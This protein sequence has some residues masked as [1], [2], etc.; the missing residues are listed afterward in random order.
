MATRSPTKATAANDLKAR[1]L[2]DA[3]RSALDDKDVARLKFS[4]VTE[5]DATAL[6]LPSAT[7]GYKIPYFDIDGKPTTFFRA[8]FLEDTRKGFAAYTDK[9]PIK[10]GQP[11][12]SVTEVYLPPLVN[13]RTILGKEVPIVI[14]E[15]EKKAACAT[16]HGIPTVGLGGVWSFMSK[17]H[18]KHLLDIFH[19]MNL[20]GRMVIICF[21]SDAATN[22]DIVNAENVL[23][24]RLTAEGAQVLIARIQ[25]EGDAK[26]GMDDYILAHGAGAFKAQ[27][28]D[29]AFEYG[30]CKAL[31]TMNE[32]MVYVR[33]PGLL[34]DYANKMKLS[35]A[36][37]VQHAYS[38]A[39][40]TVVTQ[41]KEGNKITRVN[42]AKAWMEWEHR[43]ELRG[44]VYEPGSPEITDAGYLN[45]WTGWGF[46]EPKKGDIKPW[47][48]LLGHLFG[49]AA[50][51][52]HWFECWLAWPI[53]H[54]GYKMASAALLWGAAQGSGKTLIGHTMMKLYGKN[55]AE[56]KDHDLESPRNEWAENK[57][58]I[59]ADDITGSSNRRL[60]NRLKTMITQKELRL[61]P[62]FIPSYSVRDC[63]NYYFTSNDPDALFLDDGDRRFFIHEVMA[64]KL[65]VDQR[66]AFV[67]WMESEDGIAALAHY[68]L[69]MDTGDFDPRAEAFETG[70]KREMKVIAKSELGVWVSRLKEDAKGLLNGHSEKFGD[71]F[72]AEELHA[73]F[74]PNG[75]KRATPNAMARELKR[76]GFFYPAGD[77]PLKTAE[78]MR[79]A[80]AIINTESWRTAKYVEAVKHFEDHRTMDA[81]KKSGRKY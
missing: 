44:I 22:P 66:K 75:E 64:G 71:L 25:P 63:I 26:M 41:Q 67:S 60:A 38:N 2:A 11:N 59:L 18:G 55:G 49:G 34:Y 21:D 42:T 4:V 1:M 30:P 17:K 48:D 36:Q 16:K 54:P 37:F 5:A 15:G 50:A 80:Y 19:E 52:R 8:R 6:K 23:A 79:R 47:L 9:K 45:G 58:F 78:G 14:T 40:H 46:K 33:D 76:A 68:L 31:H 27:V 74:D 81:K 24:D 3:A 29:M 53:K 12:G 73:I 56:I 61:D 51:A 69:T 7:I 65:S 72:T 43:A 70:S 10:Y 39:W 77:S 28:L 20:D 62:K 35:A 13:W 57:Q 32:K